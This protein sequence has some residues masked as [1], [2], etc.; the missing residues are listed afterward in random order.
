MKVIRY[1]SRTTNTTYFVKYTFIHSI[2]C[3][4]AFKMKTI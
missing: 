3:K 2:S 1:K 4:A